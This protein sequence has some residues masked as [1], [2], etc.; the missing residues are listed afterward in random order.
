M[1]RSKKLHPTGDEST[2][3][4]IVDVHSLGKETGMGLNWGGLEAIVID[5]SKIAE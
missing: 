1:K 3:A 2:L 5:I 4:G